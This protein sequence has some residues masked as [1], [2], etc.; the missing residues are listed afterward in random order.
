MTIAEYKKWKAKNVKRTSFKK[1][2]NTFTDYNG[3]RYHSK[4]E[5]EYAQQLDF[6]LKK[7][8]LYDW[9]RQITFP[10]EVAGE[11]I[12][13]VIV[14]FELTWKEGEKPQYW[15]VK[16]LPTMTPEWKLK[17]KLLKALYPDILFHV[18]T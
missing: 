15:E 8:Q 1:Y 7:K 5:A 13:N 18:V 9:K 12:C 3:V 16:S 4:R 6:M 17:F 14:D 10:I 2:H 11:H